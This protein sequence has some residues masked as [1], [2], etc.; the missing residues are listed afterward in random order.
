MHSPSQQCLLKRIGTWLCK[1]TV[2]MLVVGAGY[3][4]FL[5]S[6]KSLLFMQMSC[7]LDFS[8][9][10]EAAKVLHNLL[11][12]NYTFCDIFSWVLD[13]TAITQGWSS[14]SCFIQVISFSSPLQKVLKEQTTDLSE[15]KNPLMADKH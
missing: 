1:E 13:R 8:S 3:F 14:S 7:V 15:G 10:A 12:W 6:G 2:L 11:L 5:H 9:Y 4:A